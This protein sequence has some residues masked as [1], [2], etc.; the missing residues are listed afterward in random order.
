MWMTIGTTLFKSRRR[1]MVIKLQHYP[2]APWIRR[3]AQ[4][5]STLD[6]LFNEFLRGDLTENGSAPRIDV[7]E[8]KKEMIVLA[9][10]PGTAK[11]DLKIVVEEGVLTISGE[12]KERVKAEGSRW[13]R[14]E[15]GT[16]RFSRSLELPVPV[17]ADRITATLVNGLLRVVLPKAEQAQPREITIQ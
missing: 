7:G 8:T 14:N 4:W 11:E 9:E 17:D 10:L 13:L 15:I 6:P 12:R 16:G 1:S 5:G 3:S 2:V